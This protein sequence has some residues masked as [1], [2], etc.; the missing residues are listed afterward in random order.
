MEILIANLATAK[1]QRRVLDGKKYLVAP[2][3]ILVPGVLNGSKGPLFYPPDH[4]ANAAPKWDGMPIVV[5]HPTIM[6]KNV[7]ATHPG[8]LEKSG[9]GFVK[10][11]KIG[12]AGRNTAHGWFDEE[13]TKKV[14]VRVYNSLIAGKQIELSTG[15]FTDNEETPGVHNGK[16]YVAVAK[17]YRPDHLAILPDQIG[18][19]SINDGCG[20]LVNGSGEPIA[21]DWKAWNAKHRGMGAGQHLAAAQTHVKSFAKAHASGNTLAAKTHMDEAKNHTKAAESKAK[22]ESK[23]TISQAHQKLGEKGMKL[24]P[25]TGRTQ[26][27]KT[28][29]EITHANGERK[30]H[31]ADEI[32]GMLS[33]KT[34]A[35]SPAAAGNKRAQGLA[36]KHNAG[37]SQLRGDAQARVNAHLDASKAHAASGNHA[38]AALH[39][40]RAVKAAV[41]YSQKR[42]KQHETVARAYSKAGNHKMA[43]AYSAKADYHKSHIASLQG[44]KMVRNAADLFPRGE[45]EFV[46][47]QLNQEPSVTEKQTLWQKLGTL[48]GIVEPVDNANPTGINQYTAHLGSHGFKKS[49]DIRL[50]SGKVVGETHTHPSKG[51]VEVYHTKEWNH[52]V[53]GSP[54]IYGKGLKDLQKHLGPTA[55]VAGMSTDETHTAVRTAFRKANPYPSSTQAGAVSS[56]DGAGQ[57]EPAYLD[58]VYDD[59][60]IYTQGSQTFKQKHKMGDDGTCEMVG[61]PKQVKKV[62]KYQ[63]VGNLALEPDE[64]ETVINTLVAN[65]SCGGKDPEAERETLNALSDVELIELT[66]NGGPGSGPHA[67]GGTYNKYKNIRVLSQDEHTK[68]VWNQGKRKFGMPGGAHVIAGEHVKTGKLT[69]LGWHKDEGFAKIHASHMATPP[70]ANVD[71]KNPTEV[72]EHTEEIP[73]T[74]LNEGNEMADKTPA[75]QKAAMLELMKGLTEAEFMSIAPPSIQQAVINSQNIVNKTKADLI[76]KIVANTKDDAVKARQVAM[77]QNMTP[78]QLQDILSAVPEAP[79]VNTAR[80]VLSYMGASAPA[81]GE[82]PTRNAEQ[83]KKTVDQMTPKRIDYAKESGLSV[84]SSGRLTANKN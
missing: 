59:H 80:S 83:V 9:I 15:L 21:N 39:K 31:S 46:M 42:A 65:C 82:A 75:E 70:T 49:D 12:K 32:K 66:A 61:E 25:E 7:S 1:V 19:C 44:K 20:V 45:R 2:L 16:Q 8:V 18:A 36:D 14:D 64:R 13:R 23:T 6:G 11:S 17:N 37:K 34:S 29:Y 56:V 58:A 30:R 81:G 27:G 26:G 72:G 5:Y 10:N 35:P 50:M 53:S 38:A 73:T 77:F 28:T 33:G 76:L 71:E 79:A 54:K 78:E 62:T 67:G 74:T 48:M 63:P 4:V 69:V 68:D 57:T 60:H 3:S 51:T 47:N 40:E 22:K 84:N 24:H 55:N 52:K 43:A 41:G